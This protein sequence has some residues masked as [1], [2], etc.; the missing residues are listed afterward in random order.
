MIKN[1]LF[2]LF[3]TLSGVEKRECGS[4]LRSP[5]FNQREDVLRLWQYLLDRPGGVADAGPAF[6]HTYPGAPFDDSRW[7]HVQS[8]LT[9]RIEGFLAQRALDQAPL[10]HDLYLAPVYGEKHLDKALDQ[11]LRRAAQQLDKRPRDHEFYHWQYRLEWEKHIRLETQTR[12][13]DS[14]LS[15]VGQALDVYLVSSKLRLA[16]LMEARRGVFNTAYDTTFLPA[17]LAYLEGSP[18]REVP[19]VALYFYCFRALTAGLEADFRAFRG[20]LEQQSEQLPIAERRTFLLLALNFC[21]RRLNTGEP[22]YIREALDLY[23]VGLDTGALLENGYLSRFAFKNIVALGL[24][25]EEYAWVEA[26]IHRY[27][28]YLEEKFRAANRDYNL[29]RLFFSQKNYDRAMPLLARADESDLF[30]NIDSRV[31]LLKMYYETGAWDAL[32][33]L[34]AS[35]NILLLRKKKLIG[36]HYPYY[37]NTL[38]YIQKLTRLNPRDKRAAGAF[39]AE[40]E[41][42]QTLNEKE[43]LLEQVDSGRDV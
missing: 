32:D 43:W 21:I 14:N 2:I 26:F 19:V 41:Q 38:R 28:P 36:Y 4:Y 7:R 5:Y 27:E 16:C 10:L 1:K 23:R 33:A 34:I 17:L 8:F 22:R 31:L 9:A 6:R 18:L 40:V 20:Q 25:L 3:N 11:L 12:H 42:N 29:A 15:A 37:R 39:R 13:R 24:R 35:F 30:L